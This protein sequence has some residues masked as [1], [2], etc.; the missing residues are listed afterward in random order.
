MATGFDKFKGAC[1][2]M[3]CGAISLLPFHIVRI[4]LLR[5]LKSKIGKKVGLYRGFEVRAP[6]KMSIG[7]STIIGHNAMLDARMGLVIGN[8]VNLSNEVMI[9]TLHHDYQSP[10]FA[11]TGKAVIIEDYA[12]ICSRAIILPG[13]HIGR[14]AV[15][16]AGAVVTRD[17][18][19]YAVVG[20]TPAK[21]IAERNRDLVY[22]LGNSIL[23]II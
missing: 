12:W 4:T 3:V 17:V 13:V 10:D 22:D 20:G 9:W 8:N 11:Q 5:F 6:W 15:V 1:I 18:E 21:K 23:P 2:Y 7:N 19:A 16:A 14:G